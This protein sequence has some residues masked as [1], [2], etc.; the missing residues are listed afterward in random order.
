VL[1]PH[2]S[3]A[4]CVS[5]SFLPSSLFLTSHFNIIEQFYVFIQNSITFR[6]ILNKTLCPLV[7]TSICDPPPPK[8]VCSPIILTRTFS[9]HLTVPVALRY[10]KTTWL[11]VRHGPAG[12]VDFIAAKKMADL[13]CPWVSRSSL[14]PSVR[15]SVC[16]CHRF[17]RTMNSS[18]HPPVYRCVH[19]LSLLYLKPCKVPVSSTLRDSRSCGSQYYQKC[20]TLIHLAVRK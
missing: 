8:P 10:P 11:D 6:D 19:L 13:I 7:A 20:K 17:H 18:S 1:I 5:R 9:F 16:V 12:V 15:L 14:H 3:V 2:L 4:C